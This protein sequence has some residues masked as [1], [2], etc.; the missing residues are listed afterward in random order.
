MANVDKTMDCATTSESASTATE[1]V[2]STSKEDITTEQLRRFI[3]SRQIIWGDT[4]KFYG[5]TCLTPALRQGIDAA[6]PIFDSA[7]PHLDVANAPALYEKL[8][9]IDDELA[10]RWQKVMS[11]PEAFAL[12]KGL[13]TGVFSMVYSAWLMDYANFRMERKGIRGRARRFLGIESLE[14]EVGSDGMLMGKDEEGK[15]KMFSKWTPELRETVLEELAI[16]GEWR[17]R[18]FQWVG[19][20]AIMKDPDRLDTEE[21]PSTLQSYLDVGDADGLER[22]L[23]NDADL[24]VHILGVADDL[25]IPNMGGDMEKLPGK[26]RDHFKKQYL[27]KTSKENLKGTTFERLGPSRVRILGASSQKSSSS[28][29]PTRQRLSLRGIGKHIFKRE[30]TEPESSTADSQDS[31]D[32]KDPAAASLSNEKLAQDRKEDSC[33]NESDIDE[34]S[35]LP[36]YSEH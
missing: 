18:V 25:G 1:V 35:L 30:K 36:P 31:K 17:T 29:T 4:S 8:K 28:T 26:W 34:Y 24:L 23:N 32:T 19:V 21:T 6:L 14:G 9:T 2:R 22:T 12:I 20:L 5:K 10:A 13:M 3:L 11:S 27:E 16:R 15:P 33:E 7:L